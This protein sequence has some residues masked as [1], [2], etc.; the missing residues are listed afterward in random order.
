MIRRDPLFKGC[1]RPA[2]FLGVPLAPLAAVAAPL[3]LLAIWLTLLFLLLLPLAIGVMRAMVQ[4]D[5]QQFRLLGL[6]LRCRWRNANYRFWGGASAY[7]PLT[8]Q[9]RR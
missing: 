5:E 9:R 2:M 3:L 4:S 8:F 6:K 7:R 1:T